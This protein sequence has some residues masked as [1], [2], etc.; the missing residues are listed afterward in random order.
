[1]CLNFFW[2]KLEKICQVSLLILHPQ[3]KKAYM[4]AIN[5]GL[6]ISDHRV[7]EQ[8]SKC[9]KSP[10][11][12]FGIFASHC[13]FQGDTVLSILQFHQ[14]KQ[15]NYGMLQGQN[16]LDGWQFFLSDYVLESL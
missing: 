5:L 7:P 13:S 15:N 6:W 8:N 4:L 9:I 14:G 3:M 11:F 2:S 12:I 1:M 16:V 10:K